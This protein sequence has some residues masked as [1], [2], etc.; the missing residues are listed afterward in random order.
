MTFNPNYV[1]SRNVSHQEAW[2][3]IKCGHCGSRVSSAIVAV[4]KYQ[5]QASDPLSAYFVVCVA[6]EKG[7]VV[8]GQRCYPGAS[9]GPRIEGLPE[10]VNDA[11]EEARNSM[12]V[13]AFTAAELVC[14]KILM[15]VACDKGAD[16]G[17]KF[18]QYIDYLKDEGYVTPPM[19]NW[20][21]LIRKNGNRS[22]HELTA[23]DQECAESTVMF[24]AELLRLVYEMESMSTKY[25]PAP[26]ENEESSKTKNMT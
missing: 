9:F 11:Y 16:E 26:T 21:D 25:A 6:C 2:K 20:V 4:Y 10:N 18:V 15:H 17:L 24:T 7:S 5:G 8:I 23:P 14:R 22:T 13:N 3:G 12:K 19:T 1:E